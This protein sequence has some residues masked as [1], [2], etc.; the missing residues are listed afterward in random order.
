MEKEKS[1]DGEWNKFSPKLPIEQDLSACLKANWIEWVIPG[2]KMSGLNLVKT[3][4]WVLHYVDADTDLFVEQN[5]A[6]IID[7]WNPLKLIEWMFHISELDFSGQI[8]IDLWAGAQASDYKLVDKCNVKCYIGVEWIN[9]AILTLNIEAYKGTWIPAI[10]V[11]QDMLDFLERLPDDSVSILCS[12]I[13]TTIIWDTRKRKSIA[14][15]IFRVLSPDG[16]YVWNNIWYNS[17]RS[18]INEFWENI[19]GCMRFEVYK[20]AIV[21]RKK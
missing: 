21:Y 19:K 1:L 2:I 7:Y 8:V 16:C 9:D 5:L 6:E 3:E 14:T 11:K 12:G 13:D 15:E 18:H 4:K 17:N 10:V 20:N